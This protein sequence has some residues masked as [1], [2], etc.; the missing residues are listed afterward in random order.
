MLRGITPTRAI[1]KL[2]Y[3]SFNDLLTQVLLFLMI[4]LQGP[5]VPCFLLGE[6]YC[7]LIRFISLQLSGPHVSAMFKFQ[8]EVE[9]Q[10]LWAI[11]NLGANA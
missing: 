7:S 11:V 9:V 10:I 1:C 2:P 8:N 5:F 3:L 4:L 6:R